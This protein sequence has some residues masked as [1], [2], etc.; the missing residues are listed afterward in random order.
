MTS[1]PLDARIR[2]AAQPRDTLTDATEQLVDARVDV[3]V[4]GIGNL[5]WADEGFGVRCIEALYRR[6]EMAPGVRLLD[7]GTQGVYLVDHVRDA[8]RLIVFDAID[9]GDP[10]G[11]LRLVR[12]EEVPRFTGIRKMSL[13]Q[14]GFQE[15]ISC[16]QLLG[17]VPIEMLLIGVQAG[18][19]DDYGG[20]LSQAVAN[21]VEAAVGVCLAQLASWG[22]PCRRRAVPLASAADLLGPGLDID[23]YEKGRPSEGDAWRLGDPRVVFNEAAD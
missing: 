7:G 11:R 13:H 23:S 18:R 5:L 4:L 15:V 19:L 2:L 9:Y 6:Y 1:E 3:L 12:N 10:P 17:Q 8:D 14:T 22:F 16:A 20:S 21:Q